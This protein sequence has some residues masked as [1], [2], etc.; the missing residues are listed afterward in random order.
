MGKK[1]SEEERISC[2]ARQLLI[3][4]GIVAREIARREHGIIPWS[5]LSIEL[6]RMELR[7]EIRRGF[8][9]QGLSG[10][11]YALPNAME[12]LEKIS[13][14]APVSNPPLVINSCDPANPY[15]L[16]IDVIFDKD[17]APLRIVR[18]SAN[19]FVMIDGTPI[20]WIENFGA[21]IS[22]NTSAGGERINVSF[23]AFTSHMQI[24]YHNQ[25]GLTIEFI[26]DVRPSQSSWV[27]VLQSLGFFRDKV[28]TMRL[29]W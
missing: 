23:A 8:F 18:A 2:H 25:Y 21:R 26:D 12:E 11:Q 13:T 4:Y 29:E 14:I 17:G 9:V 24:H 3:R 5:L 20:L 27:G 16:G 7:G 10:M 28:Q 19:F 22:T 6:Q 1:I 15:G